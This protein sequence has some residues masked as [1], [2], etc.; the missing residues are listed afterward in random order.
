M[1]WT[2]SSSS[3]LIACGAFQHAIMF[4]VCRSYFHTFASV[5]MMRNAIIPRGLVFLAP[6]PAVHSSY[7]TL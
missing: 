5:V 6:L 7:N 2:Y 3:M 1:A 4:P